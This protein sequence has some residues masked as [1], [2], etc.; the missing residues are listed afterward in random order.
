[1]KKITLEDFLSPLQITK[2]RR[3]YQK[4]APGTFAKTCADELI[5]PI[6]ERINV[7][8]GQ[9]NDPLFLAYLC[10]Y[11]FNEEN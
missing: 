4:S 2:A 8:L 1:M 11:V 7:R 10:E 6:I 5:G 9:E 3:L